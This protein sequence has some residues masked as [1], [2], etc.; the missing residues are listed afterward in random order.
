MKKLIFLFIL[1]LVLHSCARVGS[2]VGGKKDTIAPK[3]LF[4]TIDSSR[5]NIPV[6]TK[7]LR[8]D[9]DKYI[10][11]KDIS[12]NL[13][14]SPPI[15]KI[16]KILPNSLANKFILIQWED[17][18]KANTTY[19]FNFGNAITDHNEG[20]VLP[21]FNF[22][23]S[24][25]EKLDDLYISGV[26]KDA[27]KVTSNKDSKPIVV[28]LYPEKD[29]MDYKQKPYYI[30]KADD[31]GYFELN[32]LSPGKYRLISFEDDNTNSIYDAGK[33]KVAFLSSAIDV[34]KSI[35][36]LNL[37]LFPS[38][39][40][41]KFKEAKATL[42]GVVFLFEGQPEHVAITPITEILK[43]VKVDHK[44][45]SDTAM[46]SFDAKKLNIGT[47]SPMSLKFAY[48]INDLPKK[49][50][51]I[52]Y[53]HNA[54]D[55][56]TLN[57][58]TTVLAPNE[59]LKINSNYRLQS[60][61]ASKWSL[62]VDSLTAQSFIAEI[63]KTN[64][65]QIH[66]QSDFKAGKKYQLIIPKESVFS[67]FQSNAKSYLWDLK[68][69]AIENYGQLK[70][71]I[72]HLP[73][74]SFWLKLYNDAD[75]EVYSV[76]STSNEVKFDLVKPGNYFM[77]IFVDENNNGTWDVADFEKNKQAE[78][79]K[80]FYKPVLVKALWEIVEDWDLNDTRTLDESALAKPSP[81]S[82][83]QK[84][85]TPNNPMQNQPNTSRENLKLK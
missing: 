41:V 37:N 44:V 14:I 33:E 34:Q 62:K 75:K 19:N 71:N 63:S 55:D 23:F 57:S 60:I 36:G 21:Y 20:N 48:Q 53:K 54:K 79:A 82:V 15:K 73:K 22:A 77:K 40:A 81:S 65:Y 50:T 17:S 5:V 38:K 18:L 78:F 74:S 70:I 45:K 69:D 26:V 61:D 30:T 6:T 68:A 46:V 49:E 84:K 16:K 52:T 31:D 51:S 32:Y 35:S 8:L 83:Q 72:S 4:S 25:G 42:G 11:L 64:P 3:F 10:I 58:E 66:I 43:D 2:P 85:S 56:L 67:N 39:K 28:G 13:V 80:V 29:T 47:E 9:F 59:A 1:A 24:T 76:Y 27:L 7:Q 12:K